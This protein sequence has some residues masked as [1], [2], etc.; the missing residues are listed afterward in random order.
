MADV[1]MKTIEGANKVFPDN[2]CEVSFSPDVQINEGVNLVLL[3][4]KR[5]FQYGKYDIDCTVGE[6]RIQQKGVPGMFE[7]IWSRI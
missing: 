2:K 6:Q 7:H 1:S 4:Y 3:A 5:A